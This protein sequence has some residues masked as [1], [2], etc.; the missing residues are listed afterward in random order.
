MSGGLFFSLYKMKLRDFAA[1]VG[2]IEL[3]PFISGGKASFGSV[4]I[5]SQR[6]V[7]EKSLTYKEFPWWIKINNDS[8]KGYWA[9]IFELLYEQCNP[10]VHYGDNFRSF[11][12]QW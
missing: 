4:F 9:I 12:N 3:S 2:G 7:G 5:P 11:R 8:F 10:N 1:I 6:W